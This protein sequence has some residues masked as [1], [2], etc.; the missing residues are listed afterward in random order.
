MYH[1]VTWI[2]CAGLGCRMSQKR[3]VWSQEPV[4]QHCSWFT[5][6]SA[7]IGAACCDNVSVD[8]EGRKSMRSVH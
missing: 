4:T 8:E 5:Y 6:A 3:T 1:Y 2:W 7:L